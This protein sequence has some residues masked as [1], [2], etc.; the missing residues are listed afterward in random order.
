MGSIIGALYN[1]GT[2]RRGEAYDSEKL[3]LVTSAPINSGVETSLMPVRLY[4]MAW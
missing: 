3:T 4:G 1:F 2:V